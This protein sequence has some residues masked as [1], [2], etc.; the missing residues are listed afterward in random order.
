M[1]AA[2]LGLQWC[3][4]LFARRSITSARK[5]AIF[6]TLG[7]GNRARN[8]VIYIIKFILICVIVELYVKYH[9]TQDEMIVQ[10]VGNKVVARLCC[11]I[12][13]LCLSAT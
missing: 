2:S 9:V 5:N 1:C 6:M 11:F 3:H 7:L 8:F 12:H 10:N 4:D 13:F